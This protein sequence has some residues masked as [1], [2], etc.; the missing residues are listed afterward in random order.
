MMN[1]H[2]PDYHQNY[3]DALT[4]IWLKSKV[5]QAKIDENWA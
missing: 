1:W 2:N 5:G 4:P 3:L